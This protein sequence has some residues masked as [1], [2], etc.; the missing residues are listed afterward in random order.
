MTINDIRKDLI[1]A[2]PTRNEALSV[3]AMV[4][5]IRALGL[6]VFI[7]D[8]NS[9]DDTI[10]I[11]EEMDVEVFQR[12]DYGTGKGCGM[13]KAMDVTVMKRK[14]YMGII[15]CDTTYIPSD[16]NLFLPIAEDHDLIVGARPMKKIEFW[17]R[18]A[19]QMHSKFTGILHSKKV[20]DVNSGMRIMQV[21][22]FKGNLT[23]THFGQDAQM[24]SFALRNQLRFKEIPIQFGERLGESKIRIWDAVSIFYRIFSERLK[25]RVHP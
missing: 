23:A 19:N 3:K 8:S 10:R 6:E 7:V 11:A 2:L 14:K 12:E 17:H 1:I 18:L 22:K 20:M 25:K 5:Q 4:N 24:T 16:F 21:D 9:T 13:M 15:D